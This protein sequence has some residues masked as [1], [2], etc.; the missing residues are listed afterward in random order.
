MHRAVAPVRHPVRVLPRVVRG[1]DHRGGGR[2]DLRVAGHRVRPL[3][4]RPVGPADVV[5][6]DGALADTGDEHLPDAG[7]AERAHREDRAVPVVEVARDPDPAGVRRPHGEAGAGHAL[8]LHRLGPE[9]LPELLVPALAD[10]VEVQFTDGRQEAVRVVHLDRV[11]LVGDPQT[12][13]LGHRRQ[14]QHPGEEAVAVALQFGP[15]PLALDQ[16]GHRAREGAQH[17]EE[18]AGRDRVRAED[19]VRVVVL[20]GEQPAPVRVVQGGRGQD[21]LAASPAPGAGRSAGGR[22]GRLPGPRALGGRRG[23]GLGRRG[24]GGFGRGGSRDLGGHRLGR[25]RD[26]DGFGRLAGRLAGGHRD[27]LLGRWVVGSGGHAGV[28]ARR[29]IAAIGTGSQSGRCRASY[30]TSYTA[31]SVS[32]ARSSSGSPRGSEPAALA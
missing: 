12:V 27:C 4:V 5:L 1:G 9:R 19:A 24:G 20:T 22:R 3:G 30:S 28:A 16:H 29:W 31:L 8:V 7:G 32:W 6:V 23:G 17:P 25:G 26:L 10:Q 14:G 21:V 18:H 13:A 11:V 2:R 15:G